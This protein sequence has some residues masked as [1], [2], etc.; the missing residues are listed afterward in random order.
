M[1]AI[2]FGPIRRDSCESLKSRKSTSTGQYSWPGLWQSR[3]RP[4]S[5]F[6][7]ASRDPPN[8]RL[9]ARRNPACVRGH[10]AHR[11]SGSLRNQEWAC[12]CEECGGNASPTRTLTSRRKRTPMLLFV[13]RLL[14]FVEHFV[15]ER[16]RFGRRSKTTQ[17]FFTLNRGRLSAP[18]WTRSE[19]AWP[20]EISRSSAYFLITSRAS[21]SMFKVVRI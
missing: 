13:L 18:R 8:S 21:S 17:P 6:R 3:A 11:R 16:R 12:W 5:A 7:M 20:S 10:V 14:P 2:W 9:A 4:A 15:G 19:A 1:S